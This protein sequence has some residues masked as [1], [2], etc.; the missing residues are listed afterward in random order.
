MSL[1]SK[2]L[3]NS[4]KGQN[5]TMRIPGVCNYDTETTALAHC[6]LKQKGMALKSSDY[7]AAFACSDCHDAMDNHRVENADAI[8]LQAI[9]ETWGVWV[10]EGLIV[11]PTATAKKPR[12]FPKSLPPINLYGAK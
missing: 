5:C 2:A 7:W 6:P 9:N 11:T 4:A 8:W 10:E 12:I 1:K 3:R